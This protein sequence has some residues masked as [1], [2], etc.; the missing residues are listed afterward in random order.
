MSAWLLFATAARDCGV[1]LTRDCVWENIGTQTEWT[2]GG[3]HAPQDVANHAPGE[4]GIVLEATPEDFTLVDT[5]ANDG[6]F[7]CDPENVATLE[8][9]YGEGAKCPNPAFADD[10]Q[11]S[12]CAE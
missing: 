12:N 7:T 5:G 10:P 4:C 9:D 8:G 2:G 11:P 3:L 6:I 1:D